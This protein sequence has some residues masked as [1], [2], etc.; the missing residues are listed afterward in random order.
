MAFAGN[1]TSGTTGVWH[2]PRLR[3]PYPGRAAD[4]S[5][6]APGKAVDEDQECRC[7]HHPGAAMRERL[8]RLR[9][10]SS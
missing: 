5:A 6:A 4:E 7:H 3:A 9:L 2:R 8:R 1:E 10:W